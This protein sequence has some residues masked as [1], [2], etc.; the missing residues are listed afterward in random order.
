MNS[1]NIMGD[2][3]FFA[4]NKGNNF[5]ESAIEKEQFLVVANRVSDDVYASYQDSIIK[6]ENTVK[7]M[8]ELAKKYRQLLNIKVVDITGNSNRGHLLK[9]FCMLLHQ[10]V[11]LL[12]K[13]RT[14]TIMK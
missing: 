4:I 11:L 12:K 5:I 6:V 1:Q 2:L 13:H 9:I 14:T 8:Q 3:Y 7:T 10:L